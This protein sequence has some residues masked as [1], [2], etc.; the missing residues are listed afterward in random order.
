M[1]QRQNVRLQSHSHII[2]PNVLEISM[3]LITPKLAIPVPTIFWDIWICLRSV[4]ITNHTRLFFINIHRIQHLKSKC[5]LLQ[6]IF[7]W[8]AS[9]HQTLINTSLWTVVFSRS[10][11]LKLL[12]LLQIAS[13]TPQSLFLREKQL[14]TLWD[15]GIAIGTN[16]NSCIGHSRNF[17]RRKRTGLTRWREWWWSWQRRQWFRRICRG[18]RRKFWLF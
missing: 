18:N 9:Q 17:Y 5:A 1:I 2:F 4:Q 13:A 8:F 3:L 14:K 6:T 12:H 11:K 15:P 16:F 10:W 7:N